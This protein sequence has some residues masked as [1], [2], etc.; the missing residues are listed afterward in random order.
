MCLKEL[1][2]SQKEISLLYEKLTNIF[3]RYIE[4][5]ALPKEIT[6]FRL[7]CLNKKANEPADINNIRPISISSIILKLME[8]IMLK[9]LLNEI[10]NK[11][12]L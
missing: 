7:L 4:F 1:F 11:N 10:D 8:K 5:N 6:T 2:K 9:R 12:I 3:N